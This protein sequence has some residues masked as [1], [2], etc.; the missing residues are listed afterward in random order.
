MGF[1]ENLAGFLG[2]FVAVGIIWFL[3]ALVIGCYQYCK[4]KANELLVQN[5]TT[6][7]V[8]RL[9]VPTCNPRIDLRM[10]PLLASTTLSVPSASTSSGFLVASVAPTVPDTSIA[11]R[12]AIMPTPTAPL[13]VNDTD[14]PPDYSNFVPPSYEEALKHLS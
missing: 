4:Q 8:R 3:K 6:Q 5:R 11:P 14:N 9:D 7:S 13:S 10:L 12:T 1:F 2:G